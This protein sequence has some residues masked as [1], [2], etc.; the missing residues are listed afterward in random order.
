MDVGDVEEGEFA[1]GVVLGDFKAS[2]SDSV[3]DGIG[4]RSGIKDE[5]TDRER[6]VGLSCQS[7]SKVAL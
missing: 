1:E 3:G 7:T 5:E 2:T 6:I 4:T